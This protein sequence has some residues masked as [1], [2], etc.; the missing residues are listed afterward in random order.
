MMNT[1]IETVGGLDNVS[2]YRPR[3]GGSKCCHTPSSGEHAHNN[4]AHREEMRLHPWLILSTFTNTL[5]YFPTTL[6]CRSN[7]NMSTVS[8]QFF[9]LHYT[10]GNCSWE[11][12]FIKP[13]GGQPFFEKGPEIVVAIDESTRN[14]EI[15][16][17]AER[18]AVEIMST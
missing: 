7:T 17:I 12:R 14:S 13:I 15:M 8:L 3:G 5:L 11:Q 2:A 16:D 1:G 9:S 10:K 6:A 4:A 18:K